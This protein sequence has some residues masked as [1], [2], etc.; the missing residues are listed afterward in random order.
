MLRIRS[1]AALTLALLGVGG[2]AG[3]AE[4]TILAMGTTLQVRVEAREGTDPMAPLE[5]AFQEVARIEEAIS[6]W[7]SG[8]VFSR[9][10]AAGR[11]G[12]ALDAEWFEL[13]VAA[14]AQ[15][16]RTGGAFDPGLGALLQAWG[17][18]EGGRVPTAAALRAARL[19]SGARHLELEPATRRAR[20]D[21]EGAGVEEGGFGKGYALD[22]AMAVLRADG[23]QSGLL[24]FGGQLLAFGAPAR[25][26]VAHPRHR[27]KARL[28]VNLEAASLSTSGTSERGRHLLD[29]RTGRP[30]AAWGAVAVVAP[31]AFE[32]DCL[33]TAL[34]VLGPRAGLRWARA[35]GIP[36]CFLFNDG[37]V[38]MTRAFQALQPTPHS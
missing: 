29:P 6:T 9:L 26:A 24:D 21:V 5:R 31:T 7:R 19:V 38:A 18:R 34:Y 4:R 2:W 16:A 23:A 13:L 33:S 15:Q 22:R 1:H 30:C 36:A 8:S 35:E 11:E 32:A 10:N 37:R 27:G 14:K 12:L 25:V 20:W 28:S 3:T 17:V